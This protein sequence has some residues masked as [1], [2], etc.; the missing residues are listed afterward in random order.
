VAYVT[1]RGSG[2]P[3]SRSAGILGNP[4]VQVPAGDSNP[5]TARSP[6]SVARFFGIRVTEAAECECPHDPRP[7]APAPLTRRVSKAELL[8]GVDAGGRLGRAGSDRSPAAPEHL[9]EQLRNTFGNSSGTPSGADAEESRLASG[10]D[11]A[12]YE[13]ETAVAEH[14]LH[15]SV[16][17]LSPAANRVHNSVGARELPRAERGEDALLQGSFLRHG[18]GQR[19]RRLNFSTWVVRRRRRPPLCQRRLRQPSPRI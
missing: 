18:V 10:T 14:C 15:G 9:R 17:A 5:R 4:D 13:A 1:R 19:R 12:F 3:A 8:G 7:P 16:H 6:P 2:P 11:N